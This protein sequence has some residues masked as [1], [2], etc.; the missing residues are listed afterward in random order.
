MAMSLDLPAKRLNGYFK[1]SLSRV[2]LNRYPPCPS[3]DLALGVG[4]HKDQGAL[5]VLAQDDVGGLDVKRKSDGQWVRVKPVPDSYVINIG[6]L[7]QVWSNDKYESTEHRV[8]LNSERERFSFP[9]FFDPAHCIIMKP[10]EELVTEDNPA[11]YNEFSWGRF[12]RSRRSSNFQ[13]MG[14]EN[15]QISHFRKNNY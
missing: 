7:I 15:L 4:P 13:K 8:S 6:D 2:R 1:D 10:L 5:T 14:V 12:Y 9:F 11:K 3:P